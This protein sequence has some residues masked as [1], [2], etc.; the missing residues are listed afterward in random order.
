MESDSG[1]D[2]L[3]ETR[4]FSM[5]AAGAAFSHY[6]ILKEIGSGGMGVVYKA[7]D[8]SLD[9]V[10][11]LKF[12]PPHLIKNEE[13][14]KR[15]VHEAR[16]ASALDHINVGTVYEIGETPDG[17]LYIAMGFYDGPNLK[18]RIAEGRLG[19]LE[20]ID[21]AIQLARGLGQAHLRGIVHR[22]IKPSNV[23]IAGDV[24]A[25]IVDF[26][27]AKLT[28]ATRITRTGE[29]T[30]TP[31]YMSPEQVRCEEIDARSDLFSLG[32]VIYEM[33]TGGHPFRGDNQ[34]AIAHSIL[35]DRPDS[36]SSLNS[37]V[38]EA[39]DA[40]V[41]R[42]LEKCPDSRYQSA[43]EVLADLETI[44]TAVA[45]GVEARL[46]SKSRALGRSLII[47]LVCVAAVTVFVIYLGSLP[48]HEPAT[49]APPGLV[50]VLKLPHY[51]MVLAPFW[52]AEEEG[53]GEGIMMQS[54]LAQEIE[55]ALGGDEDIS[56]VVLDSGEAPRLRSDA[57]AL[58]REMN[59]DMVV[60]GNV[61]G[62]GE[63]CQV[64]PRIT[65][66]DPLVGIEDQSP[67]TFMANTEGPGPIGVREEQA[68]SIADLAILSVS[69]YYKTTDPD[70]ALTLI[71]GLPADNADRYMLQ[72]EILLQLDR[73]DE[74]IA[75][76]EM[77]SSL[78]PEA[79]LP[80]IEKG[81][82]LY[83]GDADF[84]ECEAAFMKA[85]EVAPADASGHLNLATFYAYKGHTRA[86]VSEIEKCLP[87]AG[88][89]AD[90]HSRIGA[91][92]SLAGRYNDAIEAYRTAITLA[93]GDADAR[94]GLAAAYSEMRMHDAAADELA[95]AT[96]LA[97]DEA[98]PWLSLGWV[99]IQQASYDEAVAC[100][101]QAAN[102]DPGDMTVYLGMGRAYAEL[103][104]RDEAAR[105]FQ[106][107][108][109]TER[110]LSG[111]LF[112]EGMVHLA[113]GAN[114]RSV[115]WYEDAIKEVQA[116]ADAVPDD[117]LMHYFVG[118]VSEDMGDFEQALWAYE[119]ALGCDPEVW[120]YWPQIRYFLALVRLGRLGES[121]DYLAEYL[122]E[123]RKSENLPETGL[124]PVVELYA[125][126]IGEATYMEVMLSQQPSYD[127]D[128]ECVAKYY[129]GMANLLGVPRYVSPA[130]A[131]R[132]VRLLEECIEAGRDD[133]VEYHSARSELARL[134]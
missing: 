67:E 129:L 87:L 124:L 15:F 3:D 82:A 131:V 79:P 69:K 63:G 125:G 81:W 22:D 127:R 21:I 44:R 102:R 38:P 101:K 78:S 73:S 25:K 26:G 6:R 20:A 122:S 107:A 90:T 39:L 46:K 111:P 84:T 61:I 16:A 66:V 116:A 45:S 10:V 14:R 99:R 51:R 37:D 36:P 55:G 119:D 17:H 54:L 48:R 35:N 58:G 68:S 93:P 72:G 12:L 98:F 109:A 8:E 43:E 88:T 76:Y 83:F 77:A 114:Y 53:R 13:A 49:L 29:T 123:L 92:Y 57:L 121:E 126:E 85:V 47:A 7:H 56:L 103:G 23:I 41:A 19:V 128:G 70:K 95:Q 80:H 105:A 115:G 11:A 4:P 32:V 28:D 30:G 108:V 118:L 133:L 117:F 34:A 60:W 1:R 62:A 31:A 113:M 2:G 52:A 96:R 24:T 50:A 94:C 112:T 27:L 120:W 9:R 71:D 59:A 89:N 74:A 75:A 42:A 100:F 40:I 91:A 104:E 110:A 97:P 86:A 5:P 65:V 132:A 18:Q 134:K 130:D 106:K 64:H 33:L